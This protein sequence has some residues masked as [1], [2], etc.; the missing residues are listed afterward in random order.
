MTANAALLRCVEE[1][2]VL[3]AQDALHALVVRHQR[4]IAL[5][6]VN[7]DIGIARGEAAGVVT[8]EACLHALAI[9]HYFLTLWFVSELLVMHVP[10]LVTAEAGR[11][12]LGRAREI[13][14]VIGLAALV[15]LA[16][17]H[18]CMFSRE[19]ELC[20][21]SVI[22]LEARRLPR[23]LGMTLLARRRRTKLFETVPV[24]VVIGVTH[25]ASRTRLLHSQLSGVAL[26]AGEFGVAAAQ[27]EARARPMVELIL[28]QT[29]TLGR[30]APVARLLVEEHVLVR[31]TVTARVTTVAW[32]GALQIELRLGMALTAGY[33][34]VRPLL[35]KLRVALLV[36][37]E[38]ETRFRRLP[39][40]LGV[41]S[42]ALQQCPPIKAVWLIAFVATAANLVFAKV[43]SAPRLV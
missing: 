42:F 38:F 32:F 21:L 1:L 33:V 6:G 30:V 10:M 31:R 3:V 24:R 41:A 39:R 13:Q 16:A 14:E 5:L 11:A 29:A 35:R 40:N 2:L 36:V 9:A 7:V 28:A 15:A 27:V 20:H 25:R 17:T 18:R 19:G 34:L 26:V 43:G 37:I 23:G 4:P 12:P 22:G 8:V